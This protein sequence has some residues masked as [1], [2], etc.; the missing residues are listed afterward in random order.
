MRALGFASRDVAAAAQPVAPAG[1]AMWPDARSGLRPA[2]GAR[3]RPSGQRS[4]NIRH[5]GSVLAWFGPDVV[6]RLDVEGDCVVTGDV[7]CGL[8]AVLRESR[9]PA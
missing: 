9:R 7:M 5:A 3:L 8:Q 6:A 2:A 1:R 4:P